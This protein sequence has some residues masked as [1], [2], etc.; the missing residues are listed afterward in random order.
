MTSENLATFLNALE[1]YKS[2][3]DDYT[4]AL[5]EHA[6]LFKQV[7]ENHKNGDD[8]DVQDYTNDSDYVLTSEGVLMLKNRNQAIQGGIGEL[9]GNHFLANDRLYNNNLSLSNVYVQHGFDNIIY[10]PSYNLLS[11]RDKSSMENTRVNDFDGSCVHVEKS[12]MQCD[13]YAKMNNKS[14]YGLDESCNC[15]VYESEPKIP[16]VRYKKTKTIDT[17]GGI[18]VNGLEY[19]GIMFDG[20]LYGLKQQNYA[21]NFVELY[22]TSTNNIID[23]TPSNTDT[24]IYK[25]ASCN[26]FAGNGVNRLT[27]HDFGFDA[28][29]YKTT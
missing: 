16:Y 26:M 1:E 12:V 13:S 15:Y 23:L 19:L 18:D 22:D 27:F 20:G 3:K 7:I 4:T 10:E 25:D 11:M 9:S 14:F 6:S 2:R 5:N 17:V 8:S 29:E 21:R 24:N 28:C